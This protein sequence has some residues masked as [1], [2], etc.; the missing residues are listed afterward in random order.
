M[1]QSLTS[2]WIML[3]DVQQAWREKFAL[4]EIIIFLSIFT[5]VWLEASAAI[6]CPGLVGTI[7]SGEVVASTNLVIANGKVLDITRSRT[8]LGEILQPYVGLDVTSMFPAFAYKLGH[9]A[10]ALDQYQDSVIQACV[11]HPRVADTFVTKRVESDWAKNM[12]IDD[13]GVLR[14]CR[15]P[16]TRTEIVG[17][18]YSADAFADLEWMAVAGTSSQESLICNLVHDGERI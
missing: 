7:T 17:C 14:G 13:D 8:K 12:R 5:I 6:F 2:T 1:Q 9:P 10:T 11:L 3:L 18:Y 4:V 15:K 16:G